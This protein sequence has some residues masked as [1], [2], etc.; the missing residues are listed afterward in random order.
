MEEN[1]GIILDINLTTRKIQKINL[2]EEDIKLFI[3]GRGLGMKILYD[4][5][6]PGMDPFAEE[7]PL[8]FMAGTFSGLPVPS[9]SRTCV[10]TKSPHTSP[11]KSQYDNASTVTYSNMGGFFGP[12]VRFAGYEGIVVSGKAHFPVYI[13]IE[14]EKVE[15]VDAG[16]FWGMKTDEFDIE[17][18]NELKDNDF[19]SCYI[20][21]AGEKMVSYACVLNTASRAAGR[22]GTGAVMGSKNLKAIAVKGTGMPNVKKPKEL[23]KL[24][25]DARVFFKGRTQTKWWRD[26]GTAGALKPSSDGGSMAVKNY[27]EGTF[28]D[29]ENYDAETSREKV[30]KRDFACYMCPLSCK[31]SGVVKE[32]RFKGTIVHDSPEYETGTMLGSNLMLTN[33]NDVMKAIFDGDDYGLDIISLGNTIGFL[34]EAKEKKL[35]DKEFLD[36]IDLKWNDID[37]ILKMIEKIA[38][39]EGI[40]DLASKGVKAL[41]EKIGKGSKEFAIHVKGNELAAWNVHVDSGTGISYVTSNRGACHLNGGEVKRQNGNALKDSLAVCF[42]ATGW[43]GFDNK[44]L[45]ELINSITGLNWNEDD[46]N[47]A[48]ERIYNLEKMINFREGFT[49]VDDIL[50]ERFYKEPLTVGEK[51][52]AILKRDEFKQKLH[53]YYSERGWDI[54]TSKPKPETL[55]TLNLD[56]LV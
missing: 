34:I 54:K 18:K 12:E 35:I 26:Y 9:S 27:R 19:Q 22:G 3:G 37:G 31:K 48:G 32:G 28:K 49:N 50:P 1:F 43:G 46:F 44:Q 13:K 40:G 56:F 51:K 7:N 33:I 29:I 36:G 38:K 6:K 55:K 15:I 53:D 45:T 17:F 23:M 4:R 52:G 41:S 5:I 24:V 20:G 11:V 30:W 14:D 10:V 8:I 2:A 21:P 25:D 39:R 47:K 16:K 42:F